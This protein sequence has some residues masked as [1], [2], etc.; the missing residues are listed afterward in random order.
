MLKKLG[1]YLSIDPVLLVK[2]IRVAKGFMKEVCVCMNFVMA[3]SSF[4]MK[5]KLFVIKSYI[6]L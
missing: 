1:P 3:R 5:T 6:L 2:I 4:T